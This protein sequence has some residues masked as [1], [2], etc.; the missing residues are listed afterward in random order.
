ME[1]FR[2]VEGV[3]EFLDSARREGD[4]PADL[5]LSKLNSR[6]IGDTFH[7]LQNWGANS[8]TLPSAPTVDVREFFEQSSHLPQWVDSEK[9]LEAQRFFSRYP[10]D[11][12]AT[13][14]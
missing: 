14:M 7:M 6:G 9:I 13:L 5:V 2:R 11:L 4:L 3:A 8:D 1:S 12:L 10:A